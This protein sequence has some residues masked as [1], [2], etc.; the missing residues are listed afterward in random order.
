MVSQSVAHA[1]REA[2]QLGPK[3]SYPRKMMNMTQP[4]PSFVAITSVSMHEVIVDYG[5]FT[6][7]T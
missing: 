4:I 1:R 7:E 5:S 3:D 6:E 2:D